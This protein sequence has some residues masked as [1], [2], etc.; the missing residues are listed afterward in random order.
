[1]FSEGYPLRPLLLRVKAGLA[2]DWKAATT[3]AKT[4]PRIMDDALAASYG[5]NGGLSPYSPQL[6]D[7]TGMSEE[8]GYRENAEAVSHIP[9]WGSA[10]P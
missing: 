2:G 7:H 3:S 8:R 9:A 10:D 1:V 4:N 6:E 5:R